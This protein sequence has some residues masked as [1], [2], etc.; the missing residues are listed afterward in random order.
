MPTLDLVR[1][2]GYAPLR[3]YAAIGDGR[4]VALVAGDGAIDWLCLPDMDSPSVFAAILDER[5]GGRFALAPEIPFESQRRYVPDTNVLETT[6]TTAEGVVTV[7]D[8]MT[9]GRGGLDPGRE[10]V[11]RVDGVTG[12]V[13][14]RW[15]MEPRFHYGGA[16]RLT[17]R[18]GVPVATDGATAVAIRTWDAGEAIVSERDVRGQF[19]AQAG[20]R[21]LLSLA[22][23]HQEPLVFAPR[24]EIEARLDA[25]T[26]FWRQ[27]AVERT[28]EGP[29]RDAVV[30]SALAL[31]LLVYAPSGA[32]AAAATT[33]LPEALG[34]ERNWD[35][36]FAWVRDS[37]FTL[38]ALVR[39]GC[40]SEADAF[41][42]WLL[43]ASQLTHPRLQVLYR[44]DGGAEARERTLDLEGYRG[45][46][47]VRVGNGAADQVQLD[48]YGD[49]LQTAW[50][51]VSRGGRLDADTARR[52]GEMADLVCEIWRQPDAGIWE[53]R[54]D[55][56]H[57]TQSKAMCWVALDRALRLAAGGHLRR[58]RTERWRREADA[59]QD[60]VETRCW[61]EEIG[62]Y[63]RYA[64]ATEL[65]ASLLLMTLMEYGEP[66]S[67]RH[68]ATIDA[69]RRELGYGP[70]LLRYTG[71][72]GLDGR[73]GS[74]VCCSFWLADA[75]AR[76]GRVDEAAALMADLVELANDVGLYAEEID[77]R[78]GAFLGNL[79]QGLVHLALV[80]AAVSC[81]RAGIR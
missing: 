17:Q 36:R 4:T 58:P 10:V 14:M 7:T 18:G 16:A 20:S 41:F 54:S 3:E 63:V 70:L 13:P 62:S 73:E 48:V 2:D 15:R 53:V 69:L 71:E 32:I 44:L 6:F 43:H 45:S 23:A 51:Y 60:F 80:N 25:T 81:E 5:R 64:G 39:L 74:F 29:W 56:V 30:R 27:W 21:A 66:D 19:D 57:F 47:P 55:P 31:K 12:S 46:A 68:V 79:P 52:I 11:R 72:D 35:Y 26:A 65:D 42:W 40:P 8:A 37:A 28:Y 49:Y 34:A 77:P 33:S 24:D 50:L 38:N 9:L 75:L 76:V 1:T 59:V 67:P 22:A 61:S 78:T